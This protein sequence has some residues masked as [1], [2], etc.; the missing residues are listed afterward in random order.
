MANNDKD[1]TVSEIKQAL[2]E[3]LKRTVASLARNIEDLHDREIKKSQA[4]AKKSDAGKFV[5]PGEKPQDDKY[6]ATPKDDKY[7]D[8]KTPVEAVQDKAKKKEEK[9]QSCGGKHEADKCPKGDV[10][11]SDDSPAQSSKK[12]TQ[13]EVLATSHED[14]HNPVCP[15]CHDDTQRH[16]GLAEP[17]TYTCRNCGKAV[18][19]KATPVKKDELAA[20]HGGSDG[21]KNPKAVLPGDKAPKDM[22]GDE[23]T[24]SDLKKD[25][26]AFPAPTTKVAAKK[27]AGKVAAPKAA[28]KAAAKPKTVVAAP[29]KIKSPVVRANAAKAMAAPAPTV[30]RLAGPAP[31]ST[32]KMPGNAPMDPRLA[33]PV[34]TSNFKAPASA[35]MD[36]RLA[37]PTPTSNFKAPGNQDAVN[38]AADKKAAGVGWLNSLMSRFRKPAAAPPIGTGPVRSEASVY[39]GVRGMAALH[40]SEDLALTKSL[41]DCAMCGIPEHMG[42]CG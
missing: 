11:K 4:L 26:G 42:E 39:Q 25:E 24:S 33:G 9:C 22:G 31:T 36:S 16:G 37:G 21:P 14:E 27:P 29:A 35:P 32:F 41:G 40:R 30:S 19:P 1:L 8:Q 5:K 7:A 6:P 10:K 18:A 13:A 2:A 3:T 38:L 20:V 28:P 12:R 17:K 23:H 15:T 34:P